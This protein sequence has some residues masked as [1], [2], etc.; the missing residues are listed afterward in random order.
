MGV[1]HD[2][3]VGP[4]PVDPVGFS[5]LYHEY[6]PRILRYLESAL[7]NEA[8]AEDALHEV[9]LKAWRSAPWGSG[10][11]SLRAWLFTVARTTSID[12]ARRRAH[13]QP[14]TPQVVVALADR[15]GAI[16]RDRAAHW[17]T[18]PEVYAV[19]RRLPQRHQE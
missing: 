19:L 17:I 10:N 4:L 13:T 12:H 6:G 18:E 7:R 8:E 15:R 1:A 2:I 3:P 14:V 11:D 5:E 9:F 16:A